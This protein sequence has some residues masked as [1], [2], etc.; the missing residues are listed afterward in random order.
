MQQHRNV[1]GL[2]V[3]YKTP[4]A[5]DPAYG[6]NSDNPGQDHTATPHELLLPGTINSSFLLSRRDL[7]SVPSFHVTQECGTA[8]TS[9]TASCTRPGDVEKLHF[10]WE[11]NFTCH[12]LPQAAMRLS[13]S[14]SWD[15]VAVS[16][17]KL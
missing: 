3:I 11:A 15:V 13:L 8:C 17:S 16:S 12:M 9:D 5:A 2:C 7:S 14:L 4:Q 10:V 1:A 6:C